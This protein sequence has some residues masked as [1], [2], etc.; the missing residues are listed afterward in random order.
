MPFFRFIVHGEGVPSPRG[1]MGF[2]TTRRCYGRSYEDAA[3]KALE[4]VRRDWTS[5]RSS[6]LGNGPP[7]RL[8]IEEGWRIGV[9]QIWSA[10]NRGN[11]IYIETD[12]NDDG[13]DA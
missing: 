10:P 12:D 11:V 7:T 6:R 13:M 2:Y 3:A 8:T 1:E 5:G 4:I 9:H